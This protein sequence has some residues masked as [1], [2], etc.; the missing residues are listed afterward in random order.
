MSIVL[1]C[2]D[3]GTEWLNI[4]RNCP[5]CGGKHLP[6]KVFDGKSNLEADARKGRSGSP[7]DE[8]KDSG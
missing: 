1:V 7:P 6:F 8:G 2:E 5:K 3:C 4:L